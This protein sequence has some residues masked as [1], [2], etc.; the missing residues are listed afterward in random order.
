MASAIDLRSFS[1]LLCFSVR[2]NFFGALVDA[3]LWNQVKIDPFKITQ[4]EHATTS[5]AIHLKVL[6][7]QATARQHPLR[8][9]IRRWTVLAMSRI[10][11]WVS[12]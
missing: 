8:E 1:L 11:A 4:D 10:S 2:K 12:S 6:P 3:F 5:A 7:L 9:P